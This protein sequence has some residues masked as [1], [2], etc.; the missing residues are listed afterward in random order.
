[1]IKILNIIFFLS[2]LWQFFAFGIPGLSDEETNELKIFQQAL[3]ELDQRAIA[4]DPI[5]VMGLDR[6]DYQ[7][8]QHQVGSEIHSLVDG[9]G[10]SYQYLESVGDNPES[11]LWYLPGF[12]DAPRDDI[13]QSLKNGFCA[14]LVLEKCLAHLRELDKEAADEAQNSGS[15]FLL[16]INAAHFHLM[17]GRLYVD[18]L[19]LFSGH[20]I[21][22]VNAFGKLDLDNRSFLMEALKATQIYVPKTPEQARPA[23]LT[24][25]VLATIHKKFAVEESVFAAAAL[26]VET[27]E[28]ADGFQSWLGQRSGRYMNPVYISH[29]LGVDDYI[30]RKTSMQLEG[31]Q[32]DLFGFFIPNIKEKYQ[33]A[34][35][36][37]ARNAFESVVSELSEEE[38]LKFKRETFMQPM[39]QQVSDPY[40]YK[41][42]CAYNLSLQ[43]MANELRLKLTEG[44]KNLETVLEQ[45]QQY[46]EKIF[47]STL[48]VDWLTL[49]GF[50]PE[51][52]EEVQDLFQQQ[53]NNTENYLWKWKTSLFKNTP[54]NFEPIKFHFKELMAAIPGLSGNQKLQLYQKTR[55]KIW[56][57]FKK[58]VDQE[59]QALC[60]QMK[61]GV[62][63]RIE[64]ATALSIQLKVQEK[65]LEQ[66][67]RSVLEMSPNRAFLEIFDTPKTLYRAKIYSEIDQKK[68]FLYAP[69]SAAKPGYNTCDTFQSDD[70]PDDLSTIPKC[71]KHLTFYW[72]LNFSENGE[73]TIYGKLEDERKTKV[74]IIEHQDKFVFSSYNNST[75]HLFR[76]LLFPHIYHY[77][78]QNRLLKNVLIYHKNGRYFMRKGS[79]TCAHVE[80]AMRSFL[81]TDE[82]DPHYLWTIQ[83]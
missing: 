33:N 17:G 5:F 32:I 41:F 3:N 78:A 40:G 4:A 69:R 51:E 38:V 82:I 15:S 11:V 6:A 72:D 7:K 50:V 20:F 23:E 47:N 42:F 80:N 37:K 13:P 71:Y 25:Q 65:S 79:S 44:C 9:S 75:T 19:D 24:D 43:K 36:A 1:M 57:D 58:S 34:L 70:L 2:F 64:D 22:G 21:G 45:E 10:F 77:N 60:Q 68:H 55:E 26:R 30:I 31:A 29:I 27:T 54:S 52:Y 62:T 56:P 35:L 67:H 18:L 12:Y 28:D 83:W 39:R 59:L 48:D 61:D 81:C 63:K 74:S 46:F 14:Q 66:V 8:I 53:T 73:F 16:V 49:L 76:F